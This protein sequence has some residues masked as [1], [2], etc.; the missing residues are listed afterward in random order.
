MNAT[1]KFDAGHDLAEGRFA[2]C[3]ADGA[4]FGEPKIRKAFEVLAEP[5]G[6]FLSGLKC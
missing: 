5:A 3:T 4:D 1:T 2:D 6:N